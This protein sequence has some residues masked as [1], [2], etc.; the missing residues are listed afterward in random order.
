MQTPKPK[1]TPEFIHSTPVTGYTPTLELFLPTVHLSQVTPLHWAIVSPHSTPVTGYTPTLDNCFSPQYTCHRLHPYTGQLFLPTVHLS[2]VTPL[3][4][5]I[6]PPHS[7][8]VTG[9]T[10]TLGN[11]FSP[12]Y[13]CHRLHPY[14]GQLFLPTVHLSQVTPLYWTIVPP[15]S[16]PVTPLH[17]AIVP[18]ISLIIT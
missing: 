7:T 13:T 15:H 11:C 8:P 3:H 12:Q 16:T 14:T 18:A 4:W 10:S 1:A 5:T 2:Q 17:W 6:V 9:Y